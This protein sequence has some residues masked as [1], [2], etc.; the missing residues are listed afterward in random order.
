MLVRPSQSARK[1]WQ[2]LSYFCR[3]HWRRII[4]AITILYI[5][6]ALN[7]Q[8]HPLARHAHTITASDIDFEAAYKPDPQAHHGFLPI[9]L[10]KPLCERQSW[11][12]Y[13]HRDLRRKVYD[14]FMVNDEMDWLEIRLH[15]L[16]STVDY[17]VI[18]ESPVTFTGNAKPLVVKANWEK[19]KEFHDKI[20]YHVLE[21]PPIGAK[22]TWDYEDYQR[23]AM[24]LQT[25]PTMDGDR[26]PALGDIIVVSDIDEIPRPSTMMVLRNC[27]V[28]KR[29]T[30]R[31]RFYYYSFQYRH[32]GEDW[33][34]PQATLFGGL[35]KGE[36]ILP[37]DLRNGE[38]GN[39]L[40]GWWNKADIWNA[41]WHCST[42]FETIE[43]VL[44][45]MG[46]FSH[47]SLN[48]EQFRDP[49]RIVDRVRKGKDMWDR[50][51]EKYQRVDGNEDIPEYLKMDRSRWEYLLNRDS[52]NAAF[53]DYADG[54]I[55][56]E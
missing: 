25:F 56:G 27:N 26:N 6:L 18:L 3:T 2:R 30:I 19:F 44:T 32:I 23:N 50:E 13:P 17:F 4:C 53:K 12:P 37:A 40:V 15:T 47:T 55:P 16:A 48:Q 33:A 8:K 7:N 36:T 11:K 24:F 52:N 51:G 41:G 42:C 43:Q 21:N 34:H 46:S 9:E 1:Q 22:R 14:L 38:G 54:D 29:V 39:R 20:I 5:L 28:P 10:A 35:R 31:S 45:K 49:T